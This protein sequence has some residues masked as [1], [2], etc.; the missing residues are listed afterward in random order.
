M[1]V[2]KAKVS[3]NK[4][5]KVSKVA[6]TVGSALG[7]GSKKTG[8]KRRSRLTP[9]RLAKQILVVKLKKKLW[10]AKYGGR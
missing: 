2:K 5:S 8:G 1:G 7:L 6:K 10:K 3:K 4:V 9:E